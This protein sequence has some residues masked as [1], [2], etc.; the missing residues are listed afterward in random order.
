MQLFSSPRSGAY[1]P[2]PLGAMANS[3]TCF[4]RTESACGGKWLDSGETC[5]TWPWTSVKVIIPRDESGWGYGL[6]GMMWWSGQFTSMVF[7]P[8]KNN[9]KWKE[10][11]G[12]AGPALLKTTK[13]IKDRESLRNCDR[14]EETQETWQPNTIIISWIGSWKK[15]RTSETQM[16]SGA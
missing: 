9:E 11:L 8:K 5:Q 3:I 10:G 7:L 15:K 12:S 13:L 1:F 4:Q 14:P 16:K 6:S 2:S